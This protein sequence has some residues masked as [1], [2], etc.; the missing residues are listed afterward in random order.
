MAQIVLPN[1]LRYRKICIRG[2]TSF[3]ALQNHFIR[4]RWEELERRYT[5]EYC[6]L[7]EIT[8]EEFTKPISDIATQ[9]GL[10]YINKFDGLKLVQFH[11]DGIK[12]RDVQ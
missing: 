10:D 7:L 2:K 3:E 5:H 6:K 1:L 11:L 4:E 8:F 9:K 12:T